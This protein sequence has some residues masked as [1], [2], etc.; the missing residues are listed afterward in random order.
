MREGWEWE[1]NREGICINHP[2]IPRLKEKKRKAWNKRGHEMK[3][4]QKH[5]KQNC[6][7]HPHLH[8]WN[9]HGDVNREKKQSSLSFPSF[10]IFSLLPFFAWLMPLWWSCGSSEGYR[11]NTKHHGKSKLWLIWDDGPL[12]DVTVAV[13]CVSVYTGVLSHPGD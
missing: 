8:S 6:L 4:Q 13:P 5:D 9:P 7:L 3:E 11:P 2:S 10:S 1:V 12:S